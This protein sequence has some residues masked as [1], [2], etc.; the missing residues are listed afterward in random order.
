M[1]KTK[2]QWAD[3]TWNPTT[4]CS[5][6]SEG[7][8]NC[9]AKF[10]MWPRLKA[11]SAT[12]YHG[13]EFGDV[14]CHPERLDYPL[15]FSKPT[16]FFVNSMSDVFHP[17]IPDEFIDKIF[18]A[19]ALSPR[20][21]FQ[22]L[23]KR[24][25]RMKE[26]LTNSQTPLNVQLES[27]DSRRS[28]KKQKQKRAD[29]SFPLPNV[30]LGVS[31]EDQETARERIPVLLQTPAAI[32]WISA[33]PLIESIDLRKKYWVECIEEY[34]DIG[35]ELI[36]LIDG[37]DW[38]VVGGESGPNARPCAIEWIGDIVK[39]CK[40]TKTPVFVK[41][42]GA[43]IVSTEEMDDEGK[44]F[45]WRGTS[46]DMK[47]S[48]FHDFPKELQIRQYPNNQYRQGEINYVDTNPSSR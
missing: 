4:G 43:Y 10:G 11:M 39:E 19:M 5:K 14:M 34:G 13:R 16:K 27:I 23:T 44:E 17:D 30:W 28:I 38:I 6:V 12:V 45:I 46:D 2:I 31:V 37:I 33:E 21:I 36:K 8:R 40:S 47:G 41:Q 25:V 42:M 32:R 18:A 26:Y 22:I 15:R 48:V 1:S 29:I 3:D 35:N 7:C 24:P 9:Y 20:H